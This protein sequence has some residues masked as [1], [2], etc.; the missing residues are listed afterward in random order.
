MNDV[1]PIPLH[2]PQSFIPKFFEPDPLLQGLVQA[3]PEQ[4][5]ILRIEEMYRHL[6][7]P[8]PPVRSVSHLSLIHI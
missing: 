4:F 2:K 1:S 8:V 5:F 3:Q 6:H 7:G